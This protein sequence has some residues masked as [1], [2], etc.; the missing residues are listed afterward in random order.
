MDKNVQMRTWTLTG[1]TWAFG[2]LKRSYGVLE[3]ASRKSFFFFLP[4]VIFISSNKNQNKH[5]NVIIHLHTYLNG[6]MFELRMI[7]NPL[8]LV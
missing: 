4:I 5:F 7:L 6:P 1:I 8:R 2:A 3:H